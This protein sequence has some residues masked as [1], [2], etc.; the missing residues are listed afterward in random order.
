[1][2]KWMDARVHPPKPI[3]HATVQHSMG[4]AFLRR[5]SEVRIGTF[6]EWS[7]MEGTASIELTFE[8]PRSID[9]RTDESLYGPKS[10]AAEQEALWWMRHRPDA[11]DYWFAAAVPREG[12][13]VIRA[14]DAK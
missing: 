11:S 12:W 2:R 4:C 10:E 14:S 9:V 7:N 8:I 3:T 1:M 13:S 6:G 5:G